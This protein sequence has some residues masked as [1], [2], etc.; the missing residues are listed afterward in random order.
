MG[1][2]PFLGGK[3][4]SRARFLM[5]DFILLSSENVCVETREELILPRPREGTLSSFCSAFTAATTFREKEK[6]HTLRVNIA[7]AKASFSL[8]TVLNLQEVLIPN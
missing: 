4:G 7:E 2:M 6:Q 3:E 8:L 5:Q 1:K